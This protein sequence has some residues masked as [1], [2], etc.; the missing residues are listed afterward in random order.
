M[1]AEG[2]RS[3]GSLDPSF[4]ERQIL[5]NAREDVPLWDLFVRIRNIANY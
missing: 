3:A 5:L 2:D 4:V 1:T